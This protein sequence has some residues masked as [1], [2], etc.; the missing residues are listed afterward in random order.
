MSENPYSE[1]DDA[2]FLRYIAQN[3]YMIDGNF[4]P[5]GVNLNI[6]A[7]HIERTHKLLVEQTHKAVEAAFNLR[8]AK[9]ERDEARIEV[10]MNEANHLPTMADPHR[11]AARRG[12]DCF[13]KRE[14][15]QAMDRLAKLDEELGL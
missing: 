1:L 14:R 5:E 4:L 9:R 13:E 7:D 15:E 12:W 10:C 11:E 8:Q 6:V 3:D 2:S